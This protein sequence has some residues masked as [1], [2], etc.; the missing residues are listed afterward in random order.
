[1]NQI[2]LTVLGS[3]ALLASVLVC[4]GC[5]RD[6]GDSNKDSVTS[7]SISQ[8]QISQ[9]NFADSSGVVISDTLAPAARLPLAASAIPSVTENQ[10]PP[11]ELEQLKKYEAA[12]LAYQAKI[13]AALVKYRAIPKSSDVRPLIELDK[14]LFAISKTDPGETRDLY[15]K[16]Y[17]EIGFD[18]VGSYGLEYTGALLV[19]AHKL[20]PNSPFREDTLFA[21][22]MAESDGDNEVRLAPIYEYLKEYPDGKHAAGAYMNIGDA[23]R[24]LYRVLWEFATND[25]NKGGYGYQCYAKYVTN[26]PYSDQMKK[27]RAEAIKNYQIS[28]KYVAKDDEYSNKKISIMIESLNSKNEPDE[29]MACGLAGD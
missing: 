6:L 29:V 12:K 19:E 25:I 27:A 24:D 22:L 28:Q 14:E 11:N 9:F 21:K 23:Y 18:I 5:S 16:G 17:E 3:S 4:T 2:T 13:D 8:T 7:T 15:K 20:N 10:L 1:M 26:E